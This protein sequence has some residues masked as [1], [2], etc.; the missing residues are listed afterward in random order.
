MADSPSVAATAP[1]FGFLP[2]INTRGYY[3]LLALVAIFILGPLGGVAASYMNFSLGFFIGGQVLAGILGSVVTFGYG[4][5]GRHGANYMQSMAASVAGMAAMGVLIQTMIWLGLAEPPT[6]QLVAYFLC[7]GMFG[8]GLGM[9]YTPLVVDRMQLKYPSGLAVANILRALS[10]PDLLR[11][12]I[13]RLGSGLGLGVG[14]T[15]AAEKVAAF[16]FLGRVA[17]SASNFGAGMIVGARIGVPAITVGLIGLA[18]TPWLREIGLLGPN[19]PWRKVGFL[20]SLGT[21]LGAAIVDITLVARE[22]MARHRSTVAQPPVPQEEWKQMDTRKLL[23]WAVAWGIAVIGVSAS[24]G[25]PIG[26]AVLGVALACIFVLI[27]GISVG[28]SD[29]NPISSAFVVGVTVMALAGL[30][31]PIVGLL[32]GAILLIS[33]VVGADMQQ[34]R[35]TGWR[36]GTNR[37]I[38]FRYQVIGIFMGAV[39]AVA[40]T[41]LFLAAYPVLKVDTFLHPEMKTGNWQSAMTYKFA[42]VLRGLASSE[43]TTLKLMGLGVLIGLVIQLIRLALKRSAGYQAWKERSA[44]TKAADFVIDTVILPGPYASSLGGFVEFPTAFWY[45]MGGVFSSIW[46]WVA[47]RTNKGK[48]SGAPQDMDTTSLIGG[49]LVAGEALAFLTLGIIGLLALAH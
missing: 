44:G 49:G 31:N 26:Y 25:V 22:A 40:I 12:S 16:A 1:R 20:I 37:T 28:I 45:G 33:T 43:T 8:V 46:Q 47:A 21:I 19:D 14:L 3:I 23:V 2:A 7:I 41:K 30:T 39:F 15:L 29:S 38:Q 48:D 6:W 34:D 24:M 4:A 18:L 13:A 32:A 10:D 5:E 42:G 27:N 17:F 35:S 9:L 36:L 11:R